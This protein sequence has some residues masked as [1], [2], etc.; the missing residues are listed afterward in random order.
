MDIKI[1]E[2]CG[3]PM[4]QGTVEKKIKVKNNKI[5]KKNIEGYMCS[6]CENTVVDE[7]LLKEVIE[8]EKNKYEVKLA[9]RTLTKQ[10]ELLKNH[11]PLM[12]NCLKEI[13]EE[14]GISQRQVAEAIHIN[15]QRYGSTERGSFVTNLIT[16]KLLADAMNVDIEDIH[17]I[18]YVEKN[19]YEKIRNI[20]SYEDKDGNVIYET[21]KELEKINQEYKKMSIKVDEERNRL[22]KIKKEGNIDKRKTNV[23]K[24]KKLIKDLISKRSDIL[25]TKREMEKKAKAVIST[26]K[27][28][29]SEDYNKLEKIYPEEFKKLIK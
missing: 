25:K 27:V 5:I 15:E 18:K 24:Q 7:E 20:V 10:K 23:K 9:E 26:S 2:K 19:F 6:S 12:V 22:A 28:I 8:K 17:K 29:T 14:K 3:S 4:F 21:D 16:T 1:C 11:K 13:R